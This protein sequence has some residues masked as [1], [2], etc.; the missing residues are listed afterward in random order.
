MKVPWG[1]PVSHLLWKAQ[2]GLARGALE[3]IHVILPQ[4]MDSTAQ[5]EG[6]TMGKGR[7]Q[8]QGLSDR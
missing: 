4:G 6:S 2:V 5:R 1:S 7:V 3:I 8:P